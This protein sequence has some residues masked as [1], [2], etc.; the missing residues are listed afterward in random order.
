MNQVLLAQRM[1]EADYGVAADVWS[2][3]SYKELYRNATDTERWNMLHPDQEPRVPYVSECLGGA[4]AVV[5]A[6]DYTKTLPLSL[7]RW[8][9]ESFLALGTDGFGRSEGR[10]SLRDFFEVDARYVVL[11]ALATLAR[12][13]QIDSAVPAKA[14]RD[15]GID[16]EKVNPAIS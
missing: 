4:S 12:I 5:A 1:L 9:P 15:L 6:S 14:V 7:A 13:G 16:P 2:A 8:L 3:T 10:E 11:G